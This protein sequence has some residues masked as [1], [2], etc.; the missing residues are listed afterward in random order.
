M[1]DKRKQHPVDR[2]QEIRAL[3]KDL[4]EEHDAIRDAVL[5]GTIDSDGDTYLAVIEPYESEEVDRGALRRFL[6]ND[7][8]YRS[9]LKITAHQRVLLKERGQ[10]PY[11]VK[12]RGQRLAALETFMSP[13]MAL[14]LVDGF[15]PLDLLPPGSGYLTADAAGTPRL[16]T[17][18]GV[19]SDDQALLV[20]LQEKLHRLEREYVDPYTEY[21]IATKAA[22]A[23]TYRDILRLAR[24]VLARA[25]HH[26]P[27]PPPRPVFIHTEPETREW[28]GDGEDDEDNDDEE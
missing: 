21:P 10:N 16:M 20:K 11:L 17:V 25:G 26:F 6:K 24:D 8:L 15:D 22:I 13:A 7:A 12:D 9:F 5:D 18:P 14:K 3:M 2:L 1:G 27:D 28:D 4:R 23:V 19:R